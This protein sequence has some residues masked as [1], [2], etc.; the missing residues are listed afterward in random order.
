MKYTDEELSQ[1]VVAGYARAVARLITRLENG[2][3]GARA[4]AGKLRRP[5]G[6]A[7]V[8][9]ITGAPGAGKSTLVD[10]LADSFHK[11]NKKVAVIAVDPSSPF[12]GGAV[13]GDRIRMTN[14]SAHSSVFI[15]SMASRGSLGGLSKGAIE[16][17]HVLDSAGFDLILI[18]TVGVGQAE[19]DIVRAADTCL[20]VLVP[21]MGDSVQLLK[22]GLIEIAD[23]FVINKADRDGAL[24]LEKDLYTLLSLSEPEPGAWQPKVVQCISTT[25]SG[26]DKLIEGIRSHLTWLLESP[27]GAERRVKVV[28][29]LIATL[30]IERLAD[31][32]IQQQRPLLLKLA[33]EC[34]QRTTSPLEAVDRLLTQKVELK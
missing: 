9:G 24:P 4:L 14:S 30:A 32:L 2:L 31:S 17:I 16:A 29:D 7:H 11:Q 28:A 5:S 25:G 21:G 34:V 18:E 15:R 12:S 22:A 6:R 23:L 10:Q 27:S 33:Q 20:V 26:V 13:L 8:V 1:R 3:P 19:I